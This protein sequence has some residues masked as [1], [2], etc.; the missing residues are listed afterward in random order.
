MQQELLGWRRRG[1]SRERAGRERTSSLAPHRSRKRFRNGVCHVTLR[2]RAG[3]PS[4]RSTRVVRS[5]ER[6]FA[7]GCER[8]DFRLAQYSVQRNHVHLIVEAADANAL[9]RGVRALAIRIARRGSVIGDRYHSRVLRTPLEVRNALRYVLLNAR[10]HFGASARRAEPDSASSGPWF[11]C[12]AE[13]IG[14]PPLPKPVASAR[15]WLLSTGWRKYPRI[16]LLE[17]PNG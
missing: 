5:I 15:T 13:P 12:W 11:E 14:P 6:T 4:L 10:K 9:G 17:T 7:R 1:G 3:L 2:L 16:S 8:G